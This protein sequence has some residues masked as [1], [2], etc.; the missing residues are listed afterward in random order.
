MSSDVTQQKQ[1]AA[2][3]AASLVQSGMV[4]G[5]GTGSTAILFVRRLAERIAQGELTHLVGIPTS[6]QIEAEAKRLNVPLTTLDTHPHIDL[7]V[8]GA[9]EVD[10]QLNLIK[11][12]GGALLRE[13]MVAQASQREVIIV[14]EAKLSPAL[15]T[16]WPVPI[17]V[18]PFGWRAQLTYLSGLGAKVVLR[19][20]AENKPF[21][22]DQGN[23]ILD[24]NFGPI[25]APAALAQTL[26]QR[27]GIVEH[28]LFIQLAHT[29]IVGTNS[30]VRIL[31]PAA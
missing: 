19:Q 16:Q 1:R 5:L 23:Y 2:D 17:E 9:D 12:G 27:A 31:T 21:M 18:V 4:I 29:V 7:T 8:D 15:G 22:T 14:D 24:T 11:G 28:G 20:S 25:P 3:H 30:G 26:N 6:T 13:K 10:P